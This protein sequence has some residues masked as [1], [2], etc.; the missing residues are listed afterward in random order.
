MSG[1]R[2]LRGDHLA[3]MHAQ[4]FVDGDEIG[5]KRPAVRIGLAGRE[6]M[7]CACPAGELLQGPARR[8][9]RAINARR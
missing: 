5:K 9:K 2:P 6:R 1:S 4:R 8:D 3:L 7:R